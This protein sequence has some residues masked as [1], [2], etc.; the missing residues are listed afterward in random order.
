MQTL[1]DAAR[2]GIASPAVALAAQEVVDRLAAYLAGLPHDLRDAALQGYRNITLALMASRG[3]ADAAA[4]RLVDG[5]IAR[6][7]DRLAAIEQAG[8][9]VSGRA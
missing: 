5:V 9:G 4:E 6:I 1:P 7:R 8:G 3:V 2:A